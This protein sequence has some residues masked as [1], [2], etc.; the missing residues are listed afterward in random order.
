[1]AF[2]IVP[3]VTAVGSMEAVINDGVNGIIVRRGMPVDIKEKLELL[4]ADRE[5]LTSIGKEARSY[6]FNHHSPE[7]Y[8][9]TLNGIYD[10]L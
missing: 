10:Y 4:N 1:M 2:G 6:V 5:L 8:I 9:Q 3:V 7:K